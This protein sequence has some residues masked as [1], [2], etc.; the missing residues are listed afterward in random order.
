MDGLDGVL[1]MKTTRVQVEK[2]DSAGSM[3]KFLGQL[4]EHEL[5]DALLIPKKLPGGDGFVQ[6][7]IKDQT[8]LEETDPLAPTMAV[9]SARIL[10]DL[11]SGE[12]NVR[13]GAVLKPCELRAAVELAK[14][15]Q[16][17]L[18]NVV[19]IGV[20]CVGTYPVSDYADMV[21]SKKVPS[22]QVQL[23]V[24]KSGEIKRELESSFRECCQICDSSVPI[25]TDLAFRLFGND[26]SK[27]I[28]LTVGNRIEKEL[29]D[30]LSL[31][32][33]EGNTESWDRAAQKF[34]SRRRER[35]TKAFDEIKTRNSGIEKLMQTLS[36]CIRCH[37]CMNVCPICYCKE[38]V[39]RSSVFAH[40]PDQYSRWADRKGA[41]RMP[42][43]TLIFHLTRMSHMA[44][45]CVSCG[46]CDSACPN[47][48]PVSTIFGLI[49]KEL[50]E[51]FSY[52]P[53]RDLEEDPPVSA[54]KEDELQ[55]ESGA[56]G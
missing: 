22:P 14:F 7:L 21:Q 30:R 6:C 2:N 53:G 43:D 55:A 28:V 41:V 36:T 37:N 17:N 49:G 54:F 25:N 23:K 46:M 29:T 16:V 44:T 15:L 33:K 32:L 26:L 35:R 20:D 38:C 56:D 48:L 40:R 51:M 4:M 34:I 52:V 9:Q 11:T 42:S 5:I 13:I 27:E 18:D 50:Q 39:F 47:K 31:E 19:T 3:R 10:S 24:F 12:T 8:M 1:R 45:S